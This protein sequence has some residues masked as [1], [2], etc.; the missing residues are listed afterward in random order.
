[1]KIEIL[2]VKEILYR[3]KTW[4][5][6]NAKS[7]STYEQ[8][9]C[10]QLDVDIVLLLHKFCIPRPTK[11]KYDILWLNNGNFGCY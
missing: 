9:L 3:K 1:M 5:L 6:K 2:K 10:K 7:M 4:I 11:P 8:N